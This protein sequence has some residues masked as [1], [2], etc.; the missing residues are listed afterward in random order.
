MTYTSGVPDE[1]Q[2]VLERMV[3]DFDPASPGKA[4][5]EVCAGGTLP[6]RFCPVRCGTGT[7]GVVL[8]W[9]YRRVYTFFLVTDLLR[10]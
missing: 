6:I 1:H 2:V 9:E 3:E 7:L 10:S 5:L 8:V 4:K